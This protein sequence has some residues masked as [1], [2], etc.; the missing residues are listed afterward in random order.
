VLVA[1]LA[2]LADLPWRLTIVGDRGRSPETT[3]ELDAQIARYGFSDRIN[4]TGAVT[5][6]KLSDYYAAADL[7]VLASR[8]EGYGMAYAEA[9]AH[10][11]PVVGTTAGAI[12]DTVPEVAGI[13]VPPDDVAALATVLRPL[14]ENSEPRQRLAQGA[15]IAAAR[16]PSWQ[17]QAALF[18]N[19]LEKVS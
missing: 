3:R 16:L 8:F 13:L 2:M 11:L 18:A 14:I 10:G 1:A 15:A 7:F 19:V 12:P 6:E 9:I 4:F 17:M 5:S